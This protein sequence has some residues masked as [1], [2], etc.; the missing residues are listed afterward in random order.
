[1]SKSV[2]PGATISGS[3]EAGRNYAKAYVPIAPVRCFLDIS[4]GGEAVQRVVVELDRERCP[5]TSENFRALCTGEKGTDRATGTLLHYKGTIIHR[6][7]QGFVAQG[8]DI[9]RGNGLTNH[10]SIYGRCFE[11]EALTNRHDT[12]GCLSM[13]NVGPNTNASQFFFTLGP[14]GY[15]DGK[16][17]CFGK[18]VEGLEVLRAIN[19]T[20]TPS[21][22]PSKRIVVVDSGEIRK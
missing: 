14:A 19:Q 22:V 7:E 18:V 16:H 20:A 2:S 3:P 6:V 21:S 8:G 10:V 13:A 5:L 15:L 4:I 1:M 12:I 17:V 11:D 9:M